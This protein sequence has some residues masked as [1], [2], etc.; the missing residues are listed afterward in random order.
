MI[1]ETTT[2]NPNRTEEKETDLFKNSFI[3][4][5]CEDVFK[6]SW[7][8]SKEWQKREKRATEDIKKGRFTKTLSTAKDIDNYFK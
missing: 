6:Q 4:K 7:Y 5:K 8:W 1:I 3:I 2:F